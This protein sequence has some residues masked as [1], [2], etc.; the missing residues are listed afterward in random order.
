[1]YGETVAGNFTNGT[2]YEQKLCAQKSDTGYKGLKLYCCLYKIKLA[3]VNS[4]AYIKLNLQKS[5]VHRMTR[6]TCY[7]QTCPAT[8]NTEIGA[9]YTASPI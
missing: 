1:V 2:E 4:V 8:L 6:Q 7:V 3:E 5:T 9:E